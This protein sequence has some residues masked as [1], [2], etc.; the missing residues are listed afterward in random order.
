[1][2]GMEWN[3]LSSAVVISPFPPKKTLKISKE[4]KE[5]NSFAMQKMMMKKTKNK[6]E[7]DDPLQQCVQ[8]HKHCKINKPTITR[9]EE[10]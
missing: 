5:I 2:D 4:D 7:E 1:M 3:G 10:E 6:E 9:E 8:K